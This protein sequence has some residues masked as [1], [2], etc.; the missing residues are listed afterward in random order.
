MPVGQQ[1]LPPPR[2]RD[3]S[4]ML[5][6]CR[7]LDQVAPLPEGGHAPGNLLLCLGNRRM[8]GFLK[9]PQDR[10]HFFRLLPDIFLDGLRGFSAVMALIVVSEVPSAFRASPH[11]LYLIIFSIGFPLAKDM[12]NT[13]SLVIFASLL[14]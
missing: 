9:L 10:L 6:G 2:D 5:L 4:D 14:R 11:R 7:E 1:R 3:T 8:D 12:A 13:F